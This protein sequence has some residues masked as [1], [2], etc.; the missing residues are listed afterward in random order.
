LDKIRRERGAKSP[1]LLANRAGLGYTFF[2]VIKM[3]VDGRLVEEIINR[4]KREPS[5]EKAVLFGSRARGDNTERSDYDVAVYGKVPYAVQRDLRVF[6]C[7]ELWT[8]HKIDL[9]FV[10]EKTYGKLLENIENEGVTLYEQA[11]T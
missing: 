2:K 9:V 5:V 8:L 7:E 1:Q 3:N 4:L 11:R 6:C 10:T